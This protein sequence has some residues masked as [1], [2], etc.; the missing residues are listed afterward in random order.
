MPLINRFF[1]A[2]PGRNQQL[3]ALV[4]VEVCVADRE[5][6]KITRSISQANSHHPLLH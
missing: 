4:V 6:F 1:V 2:G 5:S 3:L